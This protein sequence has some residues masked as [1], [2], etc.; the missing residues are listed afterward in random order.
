MREE[1]W[2]ELV[3]IMEELEGMHGWKEVDGLQFY[4]KDEEPSHKSNV[5]GESAFLFV[6]LFWPRRLI[7]LARSHL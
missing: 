7:P 4:T 1:K 3:K 6:W 2:A 5:L